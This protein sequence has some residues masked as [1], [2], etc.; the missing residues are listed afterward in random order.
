VPGGKGSQASPLSAFFKNRNLKKKKIY[1]STPKLK[2][3][4]Q[5]FFCPEYKTF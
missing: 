4:E 3:F 1:I 2:L 5:F